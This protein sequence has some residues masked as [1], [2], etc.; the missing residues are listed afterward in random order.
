MSKWT[1]NRGFSL[2][3]VLVAVGI[4]G[5]IAVALLRTQDN[6]QK[7][8]NTLMKNF[9][10]L[11]VLIQAEQTLRSKNNCFARRV[12]CAWRGNLYYRRR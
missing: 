10:S 8:S 4:S 5:A 6:A 7:S 9:E 2:V 3:E 1:N 12:W 11:Q